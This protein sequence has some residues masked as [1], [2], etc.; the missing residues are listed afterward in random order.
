MLIVKSK[1]LNLL[2]VALLGCGFFSTISSLEINEFWKSELALIPIQLMAL[3]Y[4]SYSRYD[5]S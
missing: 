3:I 2:I 4:T 5:R 1:Y